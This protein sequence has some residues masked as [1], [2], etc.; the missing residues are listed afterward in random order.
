MFGTSWHIGRI[1]GIPLRIHISWFL[2]FALVVWSLARYYFPAVLSQRPPWEYWGLGVMA[3]LLLFASVLVHELGHCLVA[4]R[5]RIPI[6]QITLF[7]FGGMAQIRREA[8]TPRAEFLIAIAGPVVSVL[9]SIAFGVL[10]VVPGSPSDAVAVSTLLQEINLT[11]ALFN[12]VPGYP[13]DG[14][15]V[16]RAGLWAWSKNFHKATRQ[17]ARAGQG[18]AVLLMVFGLYL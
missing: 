1:F 16:L 13:L 14:G 10:A 2:V 12:L 7:I 8:P 18:F 15:R 3:A 4:L 6:A 5:Y 17:A 11:L 9:L